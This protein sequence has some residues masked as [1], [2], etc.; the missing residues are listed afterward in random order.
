MGNKMKKLIS[1]IL[2]LLFL[3][4]C[5]SSDS[6]ID[7]AQLGTGQ[8][9]SLA[10]FAV[11]NGH[12]FA[13][14]GNSMQVF[15]ISNPE[16]PVLISQFLVNAT[17]ETL[18]ARDDSTLFMGTT[19]GMY[20]YDISAAPA[21]KL[22]SFYSHVVACDPVV[23]N[24]DYA[25]V[26]LRSENSNFN[27]S[28]SANQLDIINIKDLVNPFIESSFLLVQP[29]GLG[30]YGDTLLV[31]DNGLKVFDVSNPQSLLLLDADEDFDAVD[32]IPHGDLM[33]TVSETGLKQYRFKSGKLNFLSAL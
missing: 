6:S 4:A 15:S 12:L 18:F 26:T 10:R 21:T 30:I 28:R 19:S 13:V 8:G 24:S 29:R 5:E 11:A 25:Y 20:I 16:N 14:N 9:G 32:I 3:S 33:I 7:S 1:V 27:C 31:C 23:A 2:S 17:A 22:L